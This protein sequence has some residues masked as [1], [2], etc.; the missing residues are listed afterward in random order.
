MKPLSAGVI[1]LLLFLVTVAL[2]AASGEAIVRA[3]DLA[4]RLIQVN[5]GRFRLSVNVRLGY[6]PTPN[7]RFDGANL[8]NYDWRGASTK[9]GYR[10]DDADFAKAPGSLRVAIL[11]DSIAEG[12]WIERYE[13][14]FPGV[15]AAYL[16]ARNPK[17]EVLNFG[18]VGYNTRQEVETLKTAALRYSPD[19]VV[20]EYCLND[21]E[22]S[23]GALL[24]RLLERE[25][26]IDEPGLVP[27]LQSRWASSSALYRLIR[28]R[29]FPVVTQ[30]A[31]EA[32]RAQRLKSLSEDTVDEALAELGAELHMRK[33]RTLVAIFPR[34]GDFEHYAY[35]EEHARVRAAAERAGLEVLDLLPAFR[36]CASESSQPMQ[37]DEYHPSAAG[38]ECAGKAIG[39]ALLQK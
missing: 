19:I 28:Y 39:E 5:E 36:R 26:Q 33:L 6:E 17:A 35:S 15:L 11:G 7:L 29:F 24:E 27:T 22:R 2:C 9:L 1:N 14:T 4:P 34:F 8:Y 18:V 13:E 20:L 23:D 32:S 30:A 25:R 31:V 21:R 10:G 16:K 38:H 3:F 37:L 12:L